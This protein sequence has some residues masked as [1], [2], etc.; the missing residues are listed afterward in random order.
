MADADAEGA[1]EQAGK[2]PSDLLARV[3][4][5]LVLIPL[6]LA[7]V[8]LGG[9]FFAALMAV[10]GL[11]MALEWTFILRLRRLAQAGFL[12]GGGVAA[13]GVTLFFGDAAPTVWIAALTGVG[14]LA[15]GLG[16]AAGTRRL[17][18]V[19]AAFV[20]CWAP[21][22]AL[23]WLRGAE[24]GLW[25]VAWILLAVWSTDVGGYFVGRAVGGP[26]LAPTI[27]PNKTWSGLAGGVG[28]AV[29]VGT[30]SAVA[31]ELDPTLSYAITS[32]LLAV[33]AQIGDITE[34]AIKR[35]FGVKD[36][37]RLIPGHGGLLDRVD[38]LVFVAPL[39]ALALG[40]V[41]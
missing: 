2:A 14:A 13:L 17:S 1:S 36:S 15:V 29:I 25:L 24:D 19:G 8:W 35:H 16:L 39:V 6:A 21:V 11:V 34:S 23:V 26:K 12:L 31:F 4:S 32:G 5:A 22:Y 38:G 30:A 7:A 27:S 37:S 28:L 40:A 41:S 33:C 9:L 10:A 20:Y 18:W 3:L